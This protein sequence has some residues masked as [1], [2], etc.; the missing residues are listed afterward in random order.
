MTRRSTLALWLAAA[1]LWALFLGFLGL[2]LVTASDGARLAPGEA[3]LAAGGLPLEP[4]RP[5]SLQPGDVLLA[6][7]GHSVTALA[8]AL[9]QPQPPGFEW[10]AGQTLR[11]TLNRAG[12]VVEVP[13]TLGPYP[14]GAVLAAN[15]GSILFALLLQLATALLFWRRPA[16]PV[17]RGMFLASAAMLAATNWSLGLQVSDLVSPA[18]FWL[19]STATLG[20]Y[21]LVWAAALHVTLLFPTPWPPLA[22]RR[23]LAPLLYAAPFAALAVVLAAPGAPNALAGLAA[24][25]PVTGYTQCVYSLLALA[26]LLRGFRAARDPVARAQVRWVAAALALTLFTGVA[27]G[28]L[29]AL[30]LG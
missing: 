26:A 30:V 8:E 21:L 22:R 23:W 28:V 9:T 10:A 20:G 29:P 6:I 1:G 19:Y 27:F 11:Y 17:A 15:W 12:A 25:G 4:L 18:G 16:E 14:L 13:V 2:H 5:G 7:N 24:A 3:P